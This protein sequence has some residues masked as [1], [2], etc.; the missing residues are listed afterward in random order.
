[1]TAIHTHLMSISKKGLAFVIVAEILI[2]TAFTVVMLYFSPKMYDKYSLSVDG[3]PLSLENY[4]DYL[5]AGTNINGSAGNASAPFMAEFGPLS[6]LAVNFYGFLAFRLTKNSSN[7][8]YSSLPSAYVSIN[9]SLY[10]SDSSASTLPSGNLLHSGVKSITSAP[11]NDLFFQ[12]PLFTVF[13]ASYPYYQIVIYS[14]SVDSD[15][16]GGCIQ[17]GG[18]PCL[19][20]I[21]PTLFFH[22]RK[23]YYALC[24]IAIFTAMCIVSSLITSYAAL[25][26]RGLSIPIK[27]LAVNTKSSLAL[28]FVMPLFVPPI[29][30]MGFLYFLPIY[31]VHYTLLII[32]L[33]LYIFTS[34]STSRA[35]LLQIN[36]YNIMTSAYGR[37]LSGKR[38]NIIVGS[39]FFIVACLSGIFH[40]FYYGSIYYARGSALNSVTTNLWWTSILL[41]VLVLGTSAA[42]FCVLAG[43]SFFLLRTWVSKVDATQTTPDIQVQIIFLVYNS[44]ILTICLIVLNIGVMW[45]SE[46]LNLLT[47]YTLFI[48]VAIWFFVCLTIPGNQSHQDKESSPALTHHVNGSHIDRSTTLIYENIDDIKATDAAKTSIINNESAT[49]ERSKASWPSSD[50]DTTSFSSD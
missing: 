41:N 29:A 40:F 38:C 34:N 19:E 3:C 4:D 11:I 1:M 49:R 16:N 39:L 22:A 36:D 21:H 6:I 32:V 37:Y 33:S 30:I 47:P 24:Y 5:C 23:Q 50:D 28:A 27:Q 2:W 46:P 43:Y 25:S 20:F 12:I 44:V 42:H 45:R 26:L 13:S 17:E 7:A 31:V 15:P 18:S 35:L 8:L 10:G 48:L 9:Y 14:M